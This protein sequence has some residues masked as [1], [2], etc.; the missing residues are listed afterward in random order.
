MTTN[1]EQVRAV[2]DA[3]LYEGYLLYPTEPP[4]EE[5]PVPLAIRGPRAAVGRRT[6]PRGGYILAAQLLMQPEPGMALTIVV[7]FL[8]L[9]HRAVQQRA[10]GAFESVDELATACRT[11]LTWDEAVECELAFG[12]FDEFG[13][14]AGQTLPIVVSG[15]IDIEEIDGGR[16]VRTR[17][18]L[19]RGILGAVRARRRFAHIRSGGTQYR[20]ATGE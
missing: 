15:G 14:A 19:R 7:R 18:E 20:C 6:G 13:L 12:P 4:R 3:V 10:G 16:L 8:Q 2:A 17:A 5:E 11:W 9:Q 1:W